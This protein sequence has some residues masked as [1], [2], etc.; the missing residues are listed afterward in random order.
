[1]MKKTILVEMIR[2]SLEMWNFFFYII[3]NKFKIPS[4]CIAKY[5]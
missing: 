2:H 4:Q 1:M 5:Q 3:I